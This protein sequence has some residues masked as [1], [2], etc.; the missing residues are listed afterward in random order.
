MVF[1]HVYIWG[2]YDIASHGRWVF[3]PRVPHPKRGTTSRMS[4]MS[5][6]SQTSEVNLVATKMEV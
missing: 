4:R 6:V 2:G 1:T 5:Y 3:K